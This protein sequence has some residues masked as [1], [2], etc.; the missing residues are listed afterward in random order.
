MQNEQ[1]LDQ[2]VFTAPMLSLRRL[3]NTTLHV[4]QSQRA[5][6]AL[7]LLA[8]GKHLCLSFC[9]YNYVTT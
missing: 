3:S 4:M 7:I 1:A 8:F 9:A 6:D 2:S 5:D